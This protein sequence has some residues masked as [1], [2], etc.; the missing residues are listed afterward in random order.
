[1]LNDYNVNTKTEHSG[2]VDFN[3]NKTCNEGNGIQ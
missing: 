2:N 1:M 3:S